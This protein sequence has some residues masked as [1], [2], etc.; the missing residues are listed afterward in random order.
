MKVLPSVYS[1]LLIMLSSSKFNLHQTPYDY[2]MYGCH[3]SS[4]FDT[5]NVIR[6]FLDLVPF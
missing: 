6:R 5:E 4:G 1:L 3:W 2:E